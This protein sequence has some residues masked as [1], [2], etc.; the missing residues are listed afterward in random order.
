MDLESILLSKIETQTILKPYCFTHI[1]N[2]RNKQRR[3][4]KDTKEANQDTES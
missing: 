2:F 1:W 3:K 4:K